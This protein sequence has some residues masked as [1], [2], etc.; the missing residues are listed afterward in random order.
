MKRKIKLRD[1]TAN[2]WDNYTNKCRFS[3]KGCIL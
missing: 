2:Q 3:C 1:L